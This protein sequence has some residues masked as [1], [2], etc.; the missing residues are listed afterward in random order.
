MVQQSVPQHTAVSQ[1]TQQHL[2]HEFC[3]RH[4]F[5]SPVPVK[6]WTRYPAPAPNLVEG[7]GAGSPPGEEY[8]QTNS[9][10]D[11]GNGAGSNGVEGSLLSEGLG[12]EL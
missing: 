11:L 3:G 10:K 9:L 6:G 2:K 4:P 1:S 5:T 7:V 8:R 12:N